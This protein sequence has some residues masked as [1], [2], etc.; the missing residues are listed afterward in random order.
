M[1]MLI[2]KK[3]LLSGFMNG[4]LCFPIQNNF[5]SSPPLI[6]IELS[7]KSLASSK[8]CTI[9]NKDTLH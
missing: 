9:L 5:F 3:M 1:T 8:E 7:A 2:K 6:D 4:C